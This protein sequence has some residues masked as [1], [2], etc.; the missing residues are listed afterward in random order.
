VSK[1]NDQLNNQ[2]NANKTKHAARLKERYSYAQGLGFNS[3]ESQ[4]LMNW[5][6]DRID[7]LATERGYLK[8][9]KG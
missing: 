9:H 4:V 5:S 1:L 3:K 6:K 2:V 8:D 7:Q